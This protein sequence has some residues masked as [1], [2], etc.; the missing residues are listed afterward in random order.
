M[1]IKSK[2]RA[3]PDH[4]IPGIMFRDI[5]TL[6]KDPDGFKDTVDALVER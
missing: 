4:P 3:V 5:T 1:S 6:L 2:I